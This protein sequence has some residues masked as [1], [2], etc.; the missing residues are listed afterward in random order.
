[1]EITHCRKALGFLMNALDAV[2]LMQI[3]SF[4]RYIEEVNTNEL[5]TSVIDELKENQSTV[6]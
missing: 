6:R 1:M 5:E 4:I 3:K 2:I